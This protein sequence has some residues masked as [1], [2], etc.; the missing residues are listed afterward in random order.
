MFEALFDAFLG[1]FVNGDYNQR[2]LTKC[3]ELTFCHF[4][5]T[6]IFKIGINSLNEYL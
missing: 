1:L 3:H 2:N 5:M 4:F 6:V